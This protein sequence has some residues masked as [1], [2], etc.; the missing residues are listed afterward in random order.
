MIS[1]DLSLIYTTFGSLEEAR[2][3]ARALVEDKFVAC[4]NVFSPIDSIYRWNE[5]VE[6]STEI[7]VIFKT[8]ATLAAA[9]MREIGRRHSYECP[10][11]IRI[12]PSDV[13]ATF[14]SYVVNN[15]GDVDT[16]SGN[17]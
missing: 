1:H 3:V 14:L 17:E 2:S 13:D 8:S 7:A 9:V 16:I 6:T 12:S 10:S 15:V 5:R 11:I 4:A